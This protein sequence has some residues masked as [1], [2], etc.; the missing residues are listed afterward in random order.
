MIVGGAQDNGTLSQRPGGSGWV[1]FNGGDGGAVASDPSDPRL[2]YGE[3]VHGQVFRNDVGAAHERGSEPICGRS[4][5]PGGWSWKQ[6]PYRIE[7]AKSD[8]SEFIAPFVLDPGEPRR[9]LVGGRSL[10]RTND[11]RAANT[12]KRGPK[13]AAIKAPIGSDHW[14]NITAVHVSRSSSDR[15]VVGHKGGEVYLSRNGTANKPRWR[16]IDDLGSNPIGARRPCLGLL[17]HP[18]EP[19]LVYATF[20]GYRTGNLWSFDVAAEQW[21]NLAEAVPA[22]PIRAIAVHPQRDQWLYLATEV[23]LVVSEDGGRTWTA[24][25]AGPANVSCHDLFWM[26][27]DLVVV[28]HGRGIFRIDLSQHVEPDRV[29]VGGADGT[30]VAV[31]GAGGAVVAG[32]S[33]GDAPSAVPLV[34]GRDVFAVSAAASARVTRLG[35]D[36]T[37]SWQVDASASTGAAPARIALDDADLLLLATDDGVLSALDASDG[38]TRWTVD[39]G[40]PGRM[41]GVRAMDRWA[42]VT[43]SR[44]T[45]AINLDTRAVGWSAPLASVRP[46]LLAGGRLF[47]AT[48]VGGLTA[49]DPRTGSVQWDHTGPLL[50]AGL[51]PGEA[52]E[53]MAGQAVAFLD[54]AGLVR[55]LDPDSGERLATVGD[56]GTASV[57]IGS[58][59]TTLVIASAAPDRLSAWACTPGA[60]SWAV[61]ESWR[62]DLPAAPVAAPAV[63]GQRI[64]VPLADT[65]VTCFERDSG[66]LK[67]EYFSGRP[68]PVGVEVLWGE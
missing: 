10:W 16:R 14:S 9:L 51:A 38:A 27:N 41:A 56:G 17:V 23:G 46:P 22:A 15:V 48:A 64:I 20:G 39:L 44:S 2:Y 1:T 13:W 5:G 37:A 47:V 52:P 50:P 55:L 43:S 67:W 68:V 12:S 34:T 36:L 59:W 62:V 35:A 24:G 33:L 29:L 26:G 28:T 49:L 8:E 61:T 60:G 30:L 40:G 58:W 32:T 65:R 4:W 21:T 42:Y 54:G 63:R 11:A 31:S 53:W 7:D 18:N 25:N 66:A 19:D 57:F 6:P 45:T 3:Y